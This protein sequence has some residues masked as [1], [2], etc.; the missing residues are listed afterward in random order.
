MINCFSNFQQGQEI[1]L[2]SRASRL[3]LGPLNLLSKK[4]LGLFCSGEDDHSSI[5]NTKVKN[6]S[7]SP[8]I[9]TVR[10]L[11]KHVALVEEL[12]RTWSA[13][14][15]WIALITRWTSA[16]R[17]MILDMTES[18][19]STRVIQKAWVHA[20]SI[21]TASILGTVSVN[22]TFRWCDGWYLHC[23]TEHRNGINLNT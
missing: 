20:D 4:V 18:S 5:S 23:N 2:F 16:Y 1:F 10:C 17:C 21:Y 22:I 6:S 3:A 11:I 15:S 19:T 8:N 9:L 12:L 7:T 13:F 14:Y